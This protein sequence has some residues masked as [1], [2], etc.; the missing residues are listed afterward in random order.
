MNELV[1]YLETLEEIETEKK[2][3]R[4]AGL[5]DE[6]IAGYLDF[7]FTNFFELKFSKDKN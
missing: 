2:E 4:K 1:K 3:L 5:S 6:E 7:F